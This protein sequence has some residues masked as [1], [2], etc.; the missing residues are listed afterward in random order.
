MTGAPARSARG[1]SS[2]G[3]RRNFAR[4]TPAQILSSFG[5]TPRVRRLADFAA[6]TA[7]PRGSLQLPGVLQRV[8]D[9]KSMIGVSRNLSVTAM[10]NG[11]RIALR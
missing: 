1:R 4:L 3:G 8:H 6:L 11:T 7:R 2:E 10:R 9:R 5:E